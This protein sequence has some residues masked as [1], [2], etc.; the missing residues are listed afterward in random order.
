MPIP[1]LTCPLSHLPPCRSAPMEE[2]AALA[3]PGGRR[4]R[5]W[6][7][8][9]RNR[10]CLVLLLLLAWLGLSACSVYGLMLLLL[11]RVSGSA[12][13]VNSMPREQAPRTGT[14]RV[15]LHPRT[16]SHPHPHPHHILPY[17]P[18]ARAPTATSALLSLDLQPLPPSPIHIYPHPS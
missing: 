9:A 18:I 15:T 4:W 7:R 13:V 2:H 5:R 16:H 8:P 1:T 12:L 14:S 10:V 3:T 11:S 6:Q 17:N